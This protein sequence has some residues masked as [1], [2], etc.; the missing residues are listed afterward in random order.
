MDKDLR[1]DHAFDFL[2][3]AGF[4]QEAQKLHQGLHTN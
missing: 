2:T 4:L 3:S 1:D